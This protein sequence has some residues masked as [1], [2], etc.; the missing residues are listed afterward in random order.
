MYALMYIGTVQVTSSS[1]MAESSVSIIV[2]SIVNFTSLT[3]TATFANIMTTATST[4]SPLNTS[5]LKNSHYIVSYILA[6]AA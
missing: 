6:I 4:S 2:T 3:S 1:T 5:K